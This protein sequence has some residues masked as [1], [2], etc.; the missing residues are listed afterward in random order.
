MKHPIQILHPR[1]L[2]SLSGHLD[3]LVRGRLWLQ[4]L[5]AMFLGVGA[6]VLMGPA[7]G[8]LEPATAK[9]I[10]RWLALPGQVFL[11]LIQMVVI[12]LVFSS[13]VRGL[14]GGEE[15]GR[16]K[17]LG[18]KAVTFFLVTTVA[19]IVLG[20][21]VTALLG[22]GSSID[23]DTM[24]GLAGGQAPAAAGAQAGDAPSLKSLPSSIVGVLPDNPLLAMTESNMLHVVV[25]SVVMGLALL[26]ISP[27]KS[28]PLIELLGSLQEVCMTVVRW[29]MVLVPFAVFGLLAQVTG[30][31]GLGVLATLSAYV[32]T[33]L[34]GL[35]GL[36]L[37][38]LLLA[39][40]LGKRSPWQF[41][42]ASRSV[43]LLAFSTSSS[44]AVMPLS[45]QTADEQL[46]VRPSI[47]QF[48]IPVGATIN[49]SGTALYQ[50][51][52]T[53]FLAQVFGVDLSLGALAVVVVTAVG[54][55]IGTPATPGVGI[56]VLATILERAGIP[57]SGV[58]LII[59]VDRILDMSRTAVNVAGDL[60]ACVI[61]DRLVGGSRSA[62]EQLSMEEQQEL[63]RAATGDEVIEEPEG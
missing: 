37:L 39:A 31:V 42:K 45:I 1:S 36:M 21:G 19:A 15:P 51:A 40:V 52:A 35:L 2:K 23:P 7:V 38:F 59:G 60:T 10:G 28:K 57:S 27:K 14:A 12:P 63:R 30:Q 34:L 25:F 20:M 55:S 53:V 11:A 5:I 61:M 49:M 44:A 58:A 41:L 29:A 4:V 17:S 18:L 47:S 43:L 62:E 48:I 33:V 50:G 46:G 8:W 3:A 54:A 22:P 16:L 9:V 13:I 26:S 56:V 32:G 24:T 6:G